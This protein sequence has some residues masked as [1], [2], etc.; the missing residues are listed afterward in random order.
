MFSPGLCPV[1]TV[2]TCWLTLEKS[3]KTSIFPV[4]HFSLLVLFIRVTS[5][6]KNL[7]TWMLSA[8]DVYSWMFVLMRFFLICV[9]VFPLM[10]F[11]RDSTCSDDGDMMEERTSAWTRCF[12]ISSQEHLCF[13][14]SSNAPS[15]WIL[16]AWTRDLGFHTSS[17][18]R[19]LRARQF[20]TN[21]W[22]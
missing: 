17:A 3:N 5:L 20:K 10:C 9:P 1:W 8:I 2:I 15:R 18:Q 4:P 19:F 12:K 6:Y 13:S 14:S 7:T 11:S 16:F 21:S 22:L